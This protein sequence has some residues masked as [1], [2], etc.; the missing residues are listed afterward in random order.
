[1][2]QN[3]LSYH[4]LRA[5]AEAAVAWSAPDSHGGDYLFGMTAPQTLKSTFRESTLWS[6]PI[7]DLGLTIAGTRLEPIVAEFQR[8]LEAVGFRRLRPRYY[9]ST[10]WGVPFE[11]VAIAIPFYLADPELERLHVERAGH[12][13]GE[14]REEILRYLRHEMGHVVNYAYRLYDEPEWEERFG[15]INLR[16]DDDYRP[17]PFS[18]KHVTHLP[19]WYAQKHPDEDWAETFAV[20]ITPGLDWRTEYA[21]RP[22]ALAKLEYCERVLH[23]ILNRDPIVVDDELDEDVG[24]IRYSLA[25]FYRDLAPDVPHLNLNLDT[26]L[27]NVFPPR[28]DRGDSREAA[29]LIR[30]LEGDLL[31]NVFRWTGHFPDRTRVL[32]EHLAARARNLELTYLEAE[33]AAVTVALTTLV[34]SL[35]MNYV[36]SG[37]YL[38]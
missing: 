14:G 24:E 23:T 25:Q 33:E 26:L 30:R 28:P 13:E 11:T 5:A 17:I 18:R 36:H 6:L 20:F 2:L 29:A 1:M 10:E 37:G 19:G 16:Y 22:V 15:S 32:V 4:K 27:R 35:A 31:G 9:L 38:R 12:V 8:E 7:R 21:A 34:T 3:Y